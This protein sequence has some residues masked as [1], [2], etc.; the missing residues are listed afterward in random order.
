MRTPRFLKHALAALVVLGTAGTADAQSSYPSRPIT[1][2]VGYAPGGQADAVARAVASKL[3][4]RLGTPVLVENKPGGNAMIAARA[5]A[6]AEPDGHTLLLVTDAMATIEPQLSGPKKLDL[7]E[8]FEPII[9]LVT[10]PLVLAAAK[11]LPASSLSEL[12]ELGKEDP[13]SLNFGTSGPTT[14]HRIAGEMLQQLADFKMTHV[15]YKGTSAS[16]TDLAGGH[17]ELVIG[18]AGA[19]K[20][21]ADAGEIKLL[22]VT[23]EERLPLLPDVPAISETYPGFDI[24]TF[25]GLMAP[26]GTPDEVITLLNREINQILSDPAE[27]EALEKQGMLVAGGEPADFEAKIKADYQSRGK[28]LGEL[29]L[30]AE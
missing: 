24:V 15:P 21:L 7:A 17:V 14:P 12:V 13:E 27:R 19:L 23:S 11:D 9:N 20:P 18:G 25:I 29:N 26:E 28:I 1:I 6:Q 8:E 30:A 4:E 5:V 2:V 10:A 22:A 16:V 3:S